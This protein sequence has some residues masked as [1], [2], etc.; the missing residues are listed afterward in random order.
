MALQS[1]QLDSR[2]VIV[3]TSGRIMLRK[4]LLLE[5]SNMSEASFARWTDPVR[6]DRGGFFSVPSVDSNSA[7]IVNQRGVLSFES[8]MRVENKNA[9]DAVLAECS[10]YFFRLPVHIPDS[11]GDG[12]SYAGVD[13]YGRRFAEQ[14][15]NDYRPMCETLRRLRIEPAAPDVADAD[16]QLVIDSLRR[17]YKLPEPVDAV[18]QRRVRPEAVVASRQIIG[19]PRRR[20]AASA[21]RTAKSFLSRGVFRH[22]PTRTQARHVQSQQ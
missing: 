11:V 9:D 1:V 19:A 15:R 3:K 10:M 7:E 4:T 2:C 5:L 13:Q 20:G 21:G 14:I 18:E 6:G 22:Y 12:I 8:P 17:F 16:H